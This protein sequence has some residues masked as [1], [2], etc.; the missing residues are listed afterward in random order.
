MAK[1]IVARIRRLSA[2]AAVDFE[3]EYGDDATD[4]DLLEWLGR[5]DAS[6]VQVRDML[7]AALSAAALRLAEH[8]DKFAST[9][10]DLTE[11][12]VSANESVRLAAATR[13][14]ELLGKLR[15]LAGERAAQ[16]T[17]GEPRKA[18]VLPAPP[19]RRD[20]RP[21]HADPRVAA[22]AVDSDEDRH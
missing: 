20:A 15:K 3:A 14:L 1:R 5:G 4:A 8:A 22:A 2:S 18:W 6:A 13:G 10:V 16:Q 11:D 21:G 19:I 9:L 17:K 12:G 7:D